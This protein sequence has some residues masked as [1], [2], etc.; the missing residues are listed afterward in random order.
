M[1][2]RFKL[3]LKPYKIFKA[4]CQTFCLFFFDRKEICY[5]FWEW[6]HFLINDSLW[7]H[8]NLQLIHKK[9]NKSIG[10]FSKSNFG[11][12][13]KSNHFF[14]INENKN[15][16]WHHIW[17]FLILSW[18]LS[19][20]TSELFLSNWRLWIMR[21]FLRNVIWSSEKAASIARACRKEDDLFQLLVEVSTS[22]FKLFLIKF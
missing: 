6:L 15:K 1:F 11:L 3:K 2:C 14:S 17:Q 9:L 18:F 10:I 8:Y 4:N 22:C 12:C 20:L 21:K 19:L 5:Y 16:N 7:K 13:H